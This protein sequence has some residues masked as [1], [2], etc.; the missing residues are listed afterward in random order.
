MPRTADEENRSQ[1]IDRILEDFYIRGI[2]SLS[3]RPL[4]KRI[5]VSA[6]ALMY[7]FGSKEELTVAVLRRAGDRQRAL[8]ETI[9]AREEATPLDVCR[10]IWRTFGMLESIPLF[11]LFFEM[12]GLALQ[13]RARFPDFF[14]GAVDRWL[15]FIAAPLVRAGATRRDARIRATIVLAGFR[16]FLLDLCATEDRE[17]IERAVDLWLRSLDWLREPS[18]SP[19]TVHKALR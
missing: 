12:Y 1:L 14:P 3:L 15:D 13:D 9:R 17:R 19:R 5:G 7:H 2:G 11:R 16:G 10:A 18:P 6:A 8:F 4:A